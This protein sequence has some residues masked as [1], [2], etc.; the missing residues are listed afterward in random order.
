MKPREKKS[1]DQGHKSSLLDSRMIWPWI[2]HPA[3][4]CLSMY[5][6]SSFHVTLWS[7]FLNGNGRIKTITDISLEVQA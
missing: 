3:E 4:H 2:C 7:I 1:F 5:I 6:P